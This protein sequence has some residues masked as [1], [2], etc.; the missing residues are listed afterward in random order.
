MNAA[1]P[2]SISHAVPEARPLGAGITAS[3]VSEL[4]GASSRPPHV[5]PAAQLSARMRHLVH[6]H[7]HRVRQ[8]I[9]CDAV[10]L[11]GYDRFSNKHVEL[12]Q[13]GYST[14]SA[15]ALC[16]DF[17]RDWPK[18]VW[19]SI[20]ANDTLP[21]TVGSERDVPGSFQRSAIYT[22]VLRPE[23]FLDGVSVE[24]VF[25]RQRVGLLHV[26]SRQADFYDSE[27][28]VRASAVGEL[29]GHIVS[30]VMIG[31]REIPANSDIGV[32]R[33]DGAWM[34]PPTRGA[35]SPLGDP[36]L[37]ALIAP[38]LEFD[39]T[40]ASFLWQ[41]GRR[42]FRINCEVFAGDQPLATRNAPSE[43]NGSVARSSTSAPSSQSILVV[44]TP[45]DRPAELTAAEIR[46]LTLMIVCPSNDAIAQI[47]GI[48]ERTVHTHVGRVL[49]KLGCEKRTQAVVRAVRASIFSPFEHPSASLASLLG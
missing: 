9:P 27:L 42:W 1:V 35:E 2:A 30:S 33:H 32:L 41:H 7:L 18:K 4:A 47:L 36:A 10:Q 46:V 26:S 8:L 20:E 49:D 17:P 5:M 13:E 12:A 24:L 19:H 29:L 16:V 39:L 31:A 21:P 43:R 28:R 22:E 45:T 34:T 11:V 48:S 38:L 44:A 25:E 40:E 3:A 37:S 23:G 14:R 15:Y 6:E